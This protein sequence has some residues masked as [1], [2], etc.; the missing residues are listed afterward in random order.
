MKICIVIPVHNEARMIGTIIEK[1][2]R[3]GLAVVVVNDGSLDDSG[4]LAQEKG[5]V[6]IQH[7]EKQG[8]GV[9]LRDGFTYALDKGFDAVITMD[10]D[11]QHHVDDID[12]FIHKAQ[13]FPG[14]VISGNRMAD[15]RRMP[16]VRR[17]V[18]RLMSSTI[19]AICRQAILD[20]QCGFRFLGA[21]VLKAITLT[22]SGFEIETEVLI[23]ASR[24]GFKVH[25]IPVQT[26]YRDEMSKIDPMRDTVRFIKYLIKELVAS[27]SSK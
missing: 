6:V 1:I 19:S 11:G 20:S 8:K 15:C 3:R 4:A 17:L 25:Q 22:S 18:N 21:N 2:K 16:L 13:A 24:C 23:K 26:I 14:S 9:S 5:A 7:K 12:H 10:G 27:R